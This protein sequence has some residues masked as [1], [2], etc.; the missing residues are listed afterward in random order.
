M[1]SLLLLAAKETVIFSVRLEFRPK[2]ALIFPLLSPV[3]LLAISRYSR[4]G[5]LIAWS[6][7][8]LLLFS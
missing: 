7:I 4:S 3:L 2:V 6:S 5:I 1:I 8:L